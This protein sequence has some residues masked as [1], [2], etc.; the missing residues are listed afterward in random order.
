MPLPGTAL[1]QDALNM[2]GRYLTLA[3]MPKPVLGPVPRQE[4]ICA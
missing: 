1:T 3:G 2:A 4:G